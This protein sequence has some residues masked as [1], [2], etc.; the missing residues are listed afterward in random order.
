M[1][2][3]RTS[4]PAPNFNA[5]LAQLVD[6]ALSK[7]VCSPF[8][9]GEGYQDADRKLKPS[10]LW[11]VYLSY[12]YHFKLVYKLNH[13]LIFSSRSYPWERSS[14]AHRIATYLRKHD[15]DVEVVDF[16]AHWELDALKEFT[17]KSVTTT[18]LFFGF[19]TFFSFWNN[20]LTDFTAWLKKEYPHIK[21][22]IGGQNV[23]HTAAQNIDI[24]VDSYGEEAMLALSKALAGSSTSGIIFEPAFFGQKKVIKAIH[25]YPSF[26]LGD[27]A[28]IM[29]K[30]DFVESWEW[31][32]VEF[33]RGC[34]FS[35][36]F[37]NFP[38]LGV[39]E[40]TSRS[41]ESF[42]Y[43]MR[44]NYDNFG[45]NRYYVA[46]ETFN[47][48]LE[49]ISK[50]ADV[51]ERLTFDPFFSGFIRAD[52]LQNKSMIEEL[53]RMNFGGQYYGIETFNHQSGK[54]IGK[55]LHPD[56]IKQ[57]VLDTK[58]YFKQQNK[59]YRGTISLIVGLPYSV[60]QEW[61][62]NMQWL[63]SNWIDESLV[64]FPLIVENLE[65]GRE[66]DHTNISK[67]SKNLQKY[68]LR[69][70]GT[71]KVNFFP[72]SE[73]CLFNWKEGNYTNHEVLW[74]H[75]TMNIFDAKR[76]SNSLQDPVIYDFK[77]DCWQLGYPEHTARTKSADLTS[78]INV[79]K[80]SA[81]EKLYHANVEF[82]K[83]YSLKKINQRN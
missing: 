34:K 50:F 51:V 21:I 46:D 13:A 68:G 42:E 54:I 74:E 24:W 31:L 25:A 77:I 56:K 40:D 55:G 47:D 58:N 80:S 83:E 18:T 30:R 79:K 62:D 19:S 29:E 32:T 4:S 11:S 10:L 22:V 82:I 33:S 20:T 76:I 41:A 17:K 3:V 52:L 28:V 9:S 60:E 1:S 49:K 15:M 26:N 39:K 43:E 59:T 78:I 37:C 38:V 73:E 65:D 6:A 44:Y 81:T 69:K 36:A 67:M 5:L 48:R 63:K 75:D 71:D 35:C 12:K 57:I 61:H 45:V 70:L 7:G 8:E 14:G 64:I 27:Y 53:A 66:N 2:R 72:N 23:L 16:A